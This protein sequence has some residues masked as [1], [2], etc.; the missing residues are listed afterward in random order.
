VICVKTIET[1]II[2]PTINYEEPD[3]DCDLNCVPNVARQAQVRYVLNNSFGFGGQNAC[4][5]LGALS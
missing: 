2:H 5:V 3:P 1:G 4:L